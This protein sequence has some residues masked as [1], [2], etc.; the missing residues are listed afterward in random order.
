[1]VTTCPGD[2]AADRRSPRSRPRRADVP[3]ARAAPPKAPA[4]TTASSPSA[5]TGQVAGG[6]KPA[7]ARTASAE[8]QALIAIR[9]DA[10]RRV[11]ALTRQAAQTPEG[12][13]RAAMLKQVG[14]IKRDSEIR[15]LETKAAF[16]R[17]RGD[18]ATAGLIEGIIAA[19][20]APPAVSQGT[21]S[22]APKAPGSKGDR[23]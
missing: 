6:A 7:P 21:N 9:E 11:E 4:P 15:F 20:R 3:A 13:A 5:L 12:P 14:E 8:E 23:P 16:A 22:A 10:V 18:V 1:M 17:G 19:R 2:L